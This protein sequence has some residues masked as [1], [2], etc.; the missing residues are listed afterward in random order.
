[1]VHVFT[2]NSF[3][4]DNQWC[5]TTRSQRERSKF[6]ANAKVHVDIYLKELQFFYPPSEVTNQEL[7]DDFVRC[8]QCNGHA[9][10]IAEPC[11]HLLLCEIYV[12]SQKTCTEYN[13][14]IET[15]TKIYIPS[16]ME[17]KKK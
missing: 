17:G 8:I 1:M 15:L 11:G 16:G 3:D 10:F 7:E 2:E 13:Q 12:D 5:Y 6:F 9:N 14:P 4:L